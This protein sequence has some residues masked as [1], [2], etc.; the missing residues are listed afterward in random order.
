M[1]C[2]KFR[3]KGLIVLIRVELNILEYGIV[4]EIFDI[5]LKKLLLLKK[6]VKMVGWRLWKKG[7]K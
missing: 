2:R 7:D 5:V 6:V 4:C 3:D 1:V